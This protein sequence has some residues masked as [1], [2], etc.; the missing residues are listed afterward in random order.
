M[1]GKLALLKFDK[2]TERKEVISMEKTINN[3]DKIGFEE[4]V[5]RRNCYCLDYPVTKAGCMD[6][7]KKIETHLI[8]LENDCLSPWKHCTLCVF[9]NV[10][11]EMPIE[12]T[13]IWKDGLCRF[14][15]KNGAIARSEKLIEISNGILVKFPD[16]LRNLFPKFVMPLV[17]SSEK[18]VKVAEEPLTPPTG[19]RE[20]SIT[21][22]IEMRQ[23][24]FSADK[25]IGLKEILISEIRPFAGQ[26]RFWF[27]EESLN[28]LSQSLSGGQTSTIVVM[29][30]KDANYKYELVDGERRW[31]SAK[32]AG[33]KKLMAIVLKNISEDEQFLRSAMANFGGESH[34]EL[35]E[36]ELIRRLRLKHKLTAKQIS[37]FLVKPITWV[38]QRSPLL[39]LSP[40]VL[41]MMHPR[42]KDKRLLL[43]HGRAL[44][45][46]KDKEQQA[47]YAQK[48]F[49][50]RVHAK[51]VWMEIRELKRLQGDHAE[52]K[53]T[54][55]DD[56]RIL[57][58]S[59]NRFQ[60]ELESFLEMSVET[61]TKMFHSPSG[62]AKWPS[63]QNQI[64][65]LSKNLEVL[66]NRF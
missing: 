59:L 21:E 14:H 66:K 63:V 10:I 38:T 8:C 17:I 18:P 31:R 11:E 42:H 48:I 46:I 39:S 13:I 52:M 7:S 43:S 32:K 53:R 49:E 25:V 3:C 37:V 62:A 45:H 44:S 34:C 55:R 41:D 19:R 2:K 40:E 6:L 16:N 9:E 64:E 4:N 29:E 65:T 23:Q 33:L 47:K 51:Q 1:E 50:G 61:F 57:H 26:P 58:N 27:D 5:P 24:I 20:R 22:A 56:L 35:E 54:P 60:R 28:L 36:I 30:I 12:E 15:Y